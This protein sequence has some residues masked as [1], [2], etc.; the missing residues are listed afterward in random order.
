MHNG[1]QTKSLWL[2]LQATSY[3]AL[4]SETLLHSECETDPWK[5]LIRADPRNRTGDP[6]H[7]QLQSNIIS[8]SRIN[9]TKIFE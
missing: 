5:M 7:L 4:N 1:K 8:Y 9:P 6:E 3:V 2:V